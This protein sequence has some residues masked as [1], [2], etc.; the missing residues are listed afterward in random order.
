M[1]LSRILSI[2]CYFQTR[3]RLKL[4]LATIEPSRTKAILS[5]ATLGAWHPVA[6]T[7]N[8]ILF[9]ITFIALSIV[10]R[11]GITFANEPNH[12]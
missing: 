7:A 6:I 10:N 9:A 5:R 4:E 12:R 3:A 2:G 11:C 1:L 8:H